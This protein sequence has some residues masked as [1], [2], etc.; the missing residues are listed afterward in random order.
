MLYPIMTESRSV[1]DLNGVWKLKFDDGTSFD[2]EW[3][4]SPLTNT[5]NIIVPA[6]FNDQN[7]GYEF[8]DFFGWLWYEREFILPKNIK[9]QRTVLRID[10]ATH[11][12]KVYINGTFAIKHSGGF[13]PFEVELNPYLQEGKNRITIAVDTRV[14]HSTLPV[15]RTFELDIPTIGI[16][17]RNLPNCDF[18]N[19]TG[20]NRYIRI[21]TTPIDYIQDI[22]IIP[23]IEG[24]HG[25]IDYQIKTSNPG[26]I[27]V[28]V[29]DEQDQ[30]VAN[31]QG[32]HGQI[33][34]KNAHLWQP[35]QAYLYTLRV[36]YRE[37][38]YNENFGIRTVKIKGTE[39][40]INDKP[41]YFKGFG[42]HEDF[43]ISGRGINEVAY[44]KDLNLMKW[45]GANSFRTSHYP[46]SEEFM[47]LADQEGFVVIDEVAA[48]GLHF[49][50]P[51]FGTTNVWK[52]IE[53][54]ENHKNAIIELI[55]RDKNHPCVVMW[56]LAN[57]AAE[58]L[59]EA[60][61]YFTPLFQL[62]RD[63]DP[64]HRP[65]TVTSPEQ[66]TA[67]N[68]KVAEMIDVIALNLYYGWYSE[69]GHLLAGS[70]KL[71]QIFLDYG[72]RCPN[73]P[74]MITEYGVDTIAGMH[75]TTP[76]MFTEEYQREFFEIYSKV[77]DE[78][79]SII[80][81]HVWNFAD[82]ATEQKTTRIQGNKK[83]VFTRD[84]KPK[85]AVYWLQKRWKNIPNFNN[86][87]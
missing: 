54:H 14:D 56:C 9:N 37:D 17:K 78:F 76:T 50:S 72:V 46:Y 53:T 74:I 57:E 38:V 24:D 36:Y 18:Y 65:I 8:R 62:A 43:P 3:F 31:S 40:L 71:R 16:I 7:E 58:Q 21:Y 28:E 49:R 34:I 85:Q 80:G 20:L 84:R 75:D 69:E 82:F 83:G 66:S 5:Q 79:P 44:M 4:S 2:K 11:T 6:S 27:R 30:I 15:G 81:E 87:N 59:N 73:K 10:A 26:D 55:K 42:K 32:S 45:M 67:I 52:E 41:F 48:V 35:L 64:Q 63:I 22:I 39:F 77:F 12:A 13:I 61:D 33:I 86:K 68:N 25:I 29:L 70:G 23:S 1:F 47:R 51:Q 19:Y 60:A